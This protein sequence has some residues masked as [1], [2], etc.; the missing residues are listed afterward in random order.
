MSATLADF[1]KHISPDV[2]PCPDPIVN[3]EIVKVIQELCVKTHIMVK[4]TEVN[5]SGLSVTPETH[6]SI[7]IDLSTV[8][9]GYHMVTLVEV[10]IDGTKYIPEYFNHVGDMTSTTWDAIMEDE[11]VYFYF[12]D[13]DTLRIFDRDPTTETY[14]FLKVALKP[15]LTAVTF[16]SILHDNFLDTIVAGVKYRILGMPNKEW[17]SAKG[18]QENYIVWRRGISNIKSVAEKGYTKRSQ[19]VNPRQFCIEC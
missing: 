6:D 12:A 2:L 10:W 13:A 8:F 4:S 18:S 14:L 9:A 15:V 1:R 17:S 3:R 19:E 11:N 7:D 5:I 16:D